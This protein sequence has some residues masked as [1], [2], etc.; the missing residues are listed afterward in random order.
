M[1]DHQLIQKMGAAI[2]LPKVGEV[3]YFTDSSGN[4][5]QVD[6]AGNITAVGGGG[7]GTVH[8]DATLTGDGSVGSPLHAVA[9]FGSDTT[10]SLLNNA[11]AP[12]TALELVNSLTTNTAGSEASKWV[13][14]LLSAGSQVVALDIRPGQLL[15]PNAGSGAPSYAF[16][17]TD[18]TGHGPASGLYFD[19]AGNRVVI[20]AQGSGS[21]W[22]AAGPNIVSSLGSVRFNGG[23]DAI[24]R[25]GPNGDLQVLM[26]NDFVVGSAAA[27]ATNATHGFIQIPSSAGAPTG[28]VSLNTGKVAMEYDTTNSKL[29]VSAGGGTWKGVVLA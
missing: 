1:S 6:S 26:T 15:A 22:D 21:F 27:L 28:T 20:Q 8:T 14:K 18:S 29:W 17:D 24:R 4:L 23:S 9:Q 25:I 10:I 7:S 19:A 16:A 2:L 5:K 11:S 13:I 12:V 3:A